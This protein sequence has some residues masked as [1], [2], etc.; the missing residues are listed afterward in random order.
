MTLG[1][2]RPENRSWELEYGDFVHLII[3]GVISR[4]KSQNDGDA[5]RMTDDVYFVLTSLSE[6]ELYR[7]RHVMLS[8]GLPSG[9]SDFSDQRSKNDLFFEF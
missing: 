2:S 8:H 4:E 7:S 5:L 6:D 1:S 9:K 3:V